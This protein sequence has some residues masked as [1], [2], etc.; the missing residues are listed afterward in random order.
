MAFRYPLQSVLRLRQSIERQE[1][2]RLFAVAAVVA[3]L[4]AEIEEFERA[5]VDT[6]RAALQEMMSGCPGATVQFAALCDAAAAR[7]HRRLQVQLM[8]AERHRLEQLSVYQSARQKREIFEG[9]RERQEAVHER[10]VAHREQ[11][12]A[13][14]A[15]LIRY[16]GDFR[17]SFLPS[18][19]AKA[20][21]FGA[22]VREQGHRSAA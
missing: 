3:R 22:T 9:L 8:E 17:E 13:D 10:E 4:R 21:R 1:E 6:R 11:E 20:A 14:E 7:T 12:R 16:I 5:R 19:P 2:Q 18:S 15:F